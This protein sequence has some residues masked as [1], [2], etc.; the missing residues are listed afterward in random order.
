MSHPA[1]AQNGVLK[2]TSFPSG[3]QVFV[4]GLPTGKLTPMSVSLGIGPHEVKVQIPSTVWTPDVRLITIVEGNNDLSVTLLPALTKGDQG[5]AG[6]QGPTGPAGAQGLQG[7]QGPQGAQGQPGLT[8]PEGLSAAQSLAGQTCPAGQFVRGF[9]LSGRIVCGAAVTGGGTSSGLSLPS[10][11][12]GLGAWLAAL[13]E[14]L[15]GSYS[16]RTSLAS[17]EI[18]PLGYALCQPPVLTAEPAGASPRYGCTPAPLVSATKLADGESVAFT[19]TLDALFVDFAGQLSTFAGSQSLDGYI[20]FTGV[21]INGTSPLVGTAGAQTLGPLAQFTI[22]Y[23][24][25]DIVTSGPPLLQ[26][27]ANTVFSMAL[28]TVTEMIRAAVDAYLVTVTITA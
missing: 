12:E 13:P 1:Y 17:L 23:T 24:D 21:Q 3:A 11:A 10:L 20:L 4:D 16:Y 15:G 18:T 19:V 25:S 7:A 27:L 6:P 28:D 9:D 8:G 22:T 2:V 14:T 26:T 5:P